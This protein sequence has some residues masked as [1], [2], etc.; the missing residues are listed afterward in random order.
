LS[1]KNK[2]IAQAKKQKDGFLSELKKNK[3][4]YLMFL[5]T[6]LWYIIFRYY[7]MA[8]I[9]VAFKNFN[10]RDGIFKSPWNGFDNFEY[11]FKSGKALQVT[12]NTVMYN[13]IF[14]VIYIL[15]SAL[16]AILLAE[17][18]NKVFKKISQTMI[19]LPYFISWVVISSLV[20]RLLDYNTGILNKIVIFFGGQSIDLATNTGV[21][22][23]I[24]PY[25]YMFKWVGYGSVLF[26]AAIVGLDASCYEAA[27]IDGAN[28]FQRI[29]FITIPLLKP[30]T[31]TLVLLGVGRI[32]RGE[33]DMFYQ[34]VG[35]NSMLMDKTDIIDTFVF[36]SLMMNSNFGMASA[37][38]FYQSVLCF[39][40]I[41]A[42][43]K[44]VKVIDAD[45]ALF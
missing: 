16:L 12:L 3:L 42:V 43:N 21:W 18:T 2:D 11:F 15:C 5:P 30:T 27:K 25:L 20:Y 9:I 29:K 37:S 7:P 22:Y 6:A 33:F 34:L 1:K 31:I 35:K 28:A 23:F 8:G 39:V 4:L 44:A 19:F 38:A 36:R 45:S 13:A 41:V 32:M 26:L 40:I 17:L 14:L 10:Y 24:L